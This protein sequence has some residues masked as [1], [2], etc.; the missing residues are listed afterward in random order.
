MEKRYLDLLNKM[1]DRDTTELYVLSST[2]MACD[3]DVSDEQL[4]LLADVVENTWL[5][6]EEDKSISYIADFICQ[7]ALQECGSIDKLL[8]LDENNILEMMY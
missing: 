1:T 8:E 6:C 5:E 7:I 3:V 4:L 2:R